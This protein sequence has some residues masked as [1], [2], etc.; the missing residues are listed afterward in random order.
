MT[1]RPTLLRR[2]AS[3]LMAHAAGVLPAARSSWGEAMQRELDH[4]DGDVEAFTWAAGCVLASY[5]ER[6]RVMPLMANRYVRLVLVLLIAT[7]VVSMLFATVLTAA[8]R[9]DQL[10][11]ASFL[12][13]FTPGDDYRRFVP[14]MEATPWWLHAL[15]VS[16]AV[17]FFA[18]ALELLRN[19][20]TAFP[21]FA[22]AWLVGAAGNL[23]SESLPAHR[24]AFSFPAPM[25]MRDYVIP[26]ATVLIAV[27]VATCLWVHARFA[28]QV[29]G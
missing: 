21:L 19:R 22:A 10:R 29:S 25:I 12:G 20:R 8:Y 16:A 14:L 27:V 18:S 28:S 7:Q 6:S 13:A 1:S 2:L 3:R 4:I 26:A 23:I 5:V 11:L 15:W 9:L 17:L 24:Q